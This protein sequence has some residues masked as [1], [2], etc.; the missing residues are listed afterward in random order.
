LVI[1]PFLR[2]LPKILETWAR[3]V[4]ILIRPTDS[5]AVENLGATGVTA[6]IGAN[7]ALSRAIDPIS[8]PKPMPNTV[9]LIN[10]SFLFA[11]IFTDHDSPTGLAVP[12]TWQSYLQ[13]QITAKIAASNCDFQQLTSQ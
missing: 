3:L 4:P 8:K 7:P 6:V 1:G 2:G 12:S 10:L 5:F 13:R 11:K 9:R